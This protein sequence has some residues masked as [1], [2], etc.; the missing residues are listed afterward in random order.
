MNAGRAGT[1]VGECAERCSSWQRT[2][3]MRARRLRRQSSPSSPQHCR[4]PLSDDLCLC[5]PPLLGPTSLGRRPVS[6]TGVPRLCLYCCP[7]CGLHPGAR[8]CMPNSTTR[9]VPRDCER[10]LSRPDTRNAALSWPTGQ[11]CCRLARVAAKGTGQGD[12]LLTVRLTR[13]WACSARDG[14]AGVDGVDGDSC[15]C[16]PALGPSTKI[17]R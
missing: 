11:P 9:L 7:P 5:W 6:T 10:K 13:E 12:P 16:R 14:V 8:P 4:L 15:S 3:W 1:V 2:S 17:D